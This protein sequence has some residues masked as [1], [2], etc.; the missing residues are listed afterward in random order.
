MGAAT[1][2]MTTAEC[3]EIDAVVA[4]C[5]YADVV[6]IIESEFSKRSDLPKFFIPIIL[7][8]AKNMYD[9]DFTAVKP[10]EAVKEITVP[11]FIIHGGKDTMVPV[12]HAY[13]LAEACQNPDSKLWIVPEASHSNPYLAR[14]TEY[15]NRI[16]SFFEDAFK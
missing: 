6:S 14:P 15:M 5:S 7:F 16:V 2:L 8:I 13:R 4:D 9:V 10:L 11:I 1:S 3:K 12:Q